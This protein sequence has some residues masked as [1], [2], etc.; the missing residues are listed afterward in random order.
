MAKA[1]ISKGSKVFVW[2]L[3]GLLIVGLA[4]FGIGNFGGSVRSVGS[5]GDEEITVDEYARAIQN[6][7][8][9]IQARTGQSLSFSDAQGFGLDRQILQRLVTTA[10]LDHEMARIGLSVGDDAVRAEL[11]QVPAFQGMDGNFDPESYRFA[12][13]QANLTVAEFERSLREDAAREL[14][15]GGI[16]G[17]VAP[18]DAY[19]ERVAA[20]LGEGRS[21]RWARVGSELL[22]TETRQPTEAEIQTHYDENPGAFTAPET[23][24]ITYAW[25]TPDMLADTVEV[26]ETALRALYEERSAEYNTPER[27]LLERLVFPG[28]DAAATAAAAIEAGE[29][30]FDTLVADRGLSLEDVDLGEVSEGELGDAAAAAVFGRDDP[31]VVG[32]VETRLGPALFRINAVL[33]AQSVPFEEARDDLRGEFAAD[34]ARRVIEDIIP[35]VQDLLAGGATLEEIAEETE[36]RLGE[37][38]FT[39]D[40]EDGIA[41]YDAFREEAGLAEPG[42]FPEVRDLSDGGIFALRVDEVVAPTL[43]PLDTVRDAVVDAWRA[44]Q[45]MSRLYDM[46]SGMRDQIADGA[47]M[48]TVGLT[49]RD[50]EALRRDA[51]IEEAPPALLE[52]VFAAEVDDV[53][54]V[55]GAEAMFL[56]RLTEIVPYDPADPDI[57]ALRQSL[58][59]QQAQGIA[60]DLYALFADAVRARAGIEL[61]QA[62]IDAV[63]AQFP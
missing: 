13:E 26:D 9:N 4:G 43:R 10:A 2:I 8:R 27:R 56:A 59:R 22:V 5:V 55:E 53:V 19:A 21:F 50:E 32:P 40:S 36:M 29:T 17:A 15:R 35:Q 18:G 60:E 25:L 20:W 62:A 11:T 1:L 3:L 45:T 63:H 57:A 41:A 51:F 52:A 44:A 37:I 46:A 54:L 31:G 49:A 47:R 42:D 48:E 30:S 33:E 6:E 58:E 34:R 61:N 39:D 23:R 24:R 16:S 12:L 38:G 14:L 7:L 28:A